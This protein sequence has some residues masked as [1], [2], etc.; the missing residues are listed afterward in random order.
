MHN[1]A[2]IPKSPELYTFKGSILRFVNCISIKRFIHKQRKEWVYTK[3]TFA[4]LTIHYEQL[5][6]PGISPATQ[7]IEKELLTSTRKSMVHTSY[8]ELR[9]ENE[10]RKLKVEYIHLSLVAVVIGTKALLSNMHLAC[11]VSSN[12]HNKRNSKLKTGFVMAQGLDKCPL[13]SCD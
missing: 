12:C 11:S 9:Y 3:P 6:L 13:K 7:I 1:F 5:S 4:D 10:I 8:L 2:N